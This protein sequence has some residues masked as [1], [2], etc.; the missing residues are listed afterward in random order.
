MDKNYSISIVS[1]DSSESYSSYAEKALHG[2]VNAE[3]FL[4]E[5]YNAA[6]RGHAAFHGRGYY[7]LF[8]MLQF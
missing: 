7:M 8:V 5:A 1:T 2:D 3:R 4:R 6:Q